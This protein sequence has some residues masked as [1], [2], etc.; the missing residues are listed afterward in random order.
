M[1]K[2]STLIKWVSIFLMVLNVSLLKVF[3]I[4]TNSTVIYEVTVACALVMICLSLYRTGIK[5]N[6]LNLM[7]LIMVITLLFSFLTSMNNGKS[8]TNVILYSVKY[9]MVLLSIPIAYILC[10]EKWDF[11]KFLKLIINLTNISYLLR[12]GIS[13]IHQLTGSVIFETIA[14]EYAAENWIRNGW[15]R[16]NPPSLAIIFIPISMYLLFQTNRK[17]ERNY[18]VFSIALSLFYAAVIHG[19]RSVML[20]QILEI[21]F[22]LL[23]KKKGSK[24]Q[25]ILFVVLAIVSVI[26]MNSSI[27]EQFIESFGAEGEFEGSTTGRLE[28]IPYYF[29]LFSENFWTG[30][31]FLDY[32]ERLF[33]GSV[34]WTVA[35]LGDVGFLWTLVQ[36]GFGGLLFYIIFVIWGIKVGIK[37]RKIV[38]DMDILVWGIIFSI[39]LTG[40]NIDLFYGIYA[41]AAPI[42]LAI[43]SYVDFGSKTKIFYVEGNR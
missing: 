26:I 5:K 18:Y 11:K 39:M 24:K 43:I 7:C 21:V 16:I 23:M 41:F 3:G 27:A 31:G 15:L 35:T 2:V 9:W 38:S 6:M 25:M 14:R 28:A 30:T 20:Y 12:A 10:S 4:L 36:L 17:S 33:E 37:A 42:S 8:F 19:A 32:E 29:N 1:I 22:I 34:G 13:I 40:I